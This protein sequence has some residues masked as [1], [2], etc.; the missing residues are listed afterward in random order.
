MLSRVL[1]GAILGV[2]AYLVRVEADVAMG[3]PAFSTVGLPQIAVKEGRERVMAAIKNSGLEMPPRRVTINLAP[4]DIP[5]NGSA[6]DLPIA[7]GILVSTG[8]IPAD[9]VAGRVFIGELGLDGSLRPIRGALPIAAE[10]RRRRL[11]GLFVPPANLREARLADGLRVLPGR[12]LR[13]IVRF[14]RDGRDIPSE[15]PE[16]SV[17]GSPDSPLLD[18]ADVRG[19]LHARRAIE[20]AAAG[21][22][23]ILL[24]GPPGSGKTMLARRLPGIL[25]PL[26]MGEALEVAKVRSVAGTLNGLHSLDR[27]PPFRAPHHTISD[28]GLVGGG[29]RPRPGEVS[30]AHNG[31]LFL[32]EL[33]EFRRQVLEVLRQPME[34][35]HVS[36]ARA[37]LTLTYPARFMLVA[38]MNPCPCGFFGTSDNRCVCSVDQVR[39]YLRR[40]SGPLMD[41]IDIHIEAPAVRADALAHERP[42]EASDAIRQRV[43]RAREIQRARYR[44]RPGVDANGHMTPSE[45]RDFCA[46]DRRGR[47]LLQSAMPKLGLSARAYH[48][49]IKLART[50]ADL[51]GQDGISSAHIAEAIQYRSLDR[52]GRL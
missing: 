17:A 43:V 24:V 4:A 46:V 30:L 32:D 28:A 11:R 41:R 36:I 25:P 37:G 51:E 19:Q 10:V 3:L 27:S 50:L 52:A 1:S 15:P 2:D 14:L 38:A 12:T 26:E 48:R 16:E 39:R 7:I 45:L 13:E 20:V 6:F 5:K 49:I 18:F 23:N 35:H 44:Q 31:V 21:S 47:A 33:P 40:V 9:A 8:Q 34:A 29:S 42:A 22:H